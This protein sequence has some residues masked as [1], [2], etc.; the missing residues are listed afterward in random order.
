MRRIGISAG[1]ASLA[2]IAGIALA[3]CGGSAHGTPSGGGNPGVHN[4]PAAPAATAQYRVK[5][6]SCGPTARF[7]IA[8]VSGPTSPIGVTVEFVDAS[9]NVANTASDYTDPLSH[10]LSQH[11]G[12][13]D[14]TS[15]TYIQEPSGK[16]YNLGHPARC[17][18][19]WHHVAYGSPSGTEHPVASAP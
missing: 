17:I 9:G 14:D 6:T 16:T 3:A 11:L 8:N 1:V 10:G 12:I 4:L 5:M 19:T 15:K 13:E 18:A 7:D 2:A